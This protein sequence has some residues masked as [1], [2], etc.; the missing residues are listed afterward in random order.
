V[1]WLGRVPH[2]RVPELIR[3]ADVVVCTP[4]YEPFGIVPLEAMACGVAVVVSAVGGM[5][6]TVVHGATGVHV[7]PRRPDVVALALRNLLADAVRREAYGIAGVDRARVR[8]SW[9]RIAQETLAFYAHSREP[10]RGVDA[11]AGDAS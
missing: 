2:E 10:V 7:P 1:C 11:A 5:T 4:W 9:D 8:Y 3:S 6:D